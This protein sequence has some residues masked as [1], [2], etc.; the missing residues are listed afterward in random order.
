MERD[1]NEKEK[2]KGKERRRFSWERA[3]KT[4]FLSFSLSFIS[5]FYKAYYIHIANHTGGNTDSKREKSIQAKQMNKGEK[6]ERER[7]R[8]V[9]SLFFPFLP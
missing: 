2:E 6:R 9:M 1:G 3:T 8:S 5:L 4:L 7:E